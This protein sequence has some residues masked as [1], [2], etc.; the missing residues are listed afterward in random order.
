MPYLPAFVRL[1]TLV[2]LAG[3][4]GTVAAQA[5]PDDP[6]AR[7]ARAEGQMIRA[8]TEHFLGNDSSAVRLLDQALALAP[9]DAGVLDALA[10]VHAA[11]GDVPAALYRA[12]QAAAAAPDRPSVRVRLGRLQAQAGQR[13]AALASLQAARALDAADPEPLVALAEVYAAA[14]RAAD[15]IA[16]LEALVA[17]GD[18]PAAR[19]RLADLYVRDGEPERAAASVRAA[20]RLAPGESMLRDRL[21]ELTGTPVATPS[22][23]PSPSDD[24]PTPAASGSVDAL[25]A[26]VD[27]EPGRPDAWARLLDL[28]VRTG[29]PRAATTADDAVLFFP[30]VPA[31]LAPASEA[32]RAAGRAA[33]A[34]AAARAGLSAL[35]ALG[36]DA[37]PDADALRSR[38]RAALGG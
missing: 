15:E 7:R 34:E 18:T 14:G 32:Y 8:L 2:L 24:A 1:L 26:A 30:A 31:V 5:S 9:G 27:A 13:E 21:A 20:I 35:D 38:L 10:E 28:M 16:T 4:A 29:D 6:A 25:L 3:A 17:I 36:A 11:L 33:D 12:E 19:L 37:P 23:T 22:P